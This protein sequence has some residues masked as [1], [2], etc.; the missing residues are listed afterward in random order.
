[1][2]NA[3]RDHRARRSTGTVYP[4]ETA[5]RGRRALQK[6]GGPVLL[7]DGLLQ[8]PQLSGQAVHLLLQLADIDGALNLD[9][10]DRVAVGQGAGQFHTITAPLKSSV[11]FTNTPLRPS[12]RRPSGSPAGPAGG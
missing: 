11:V 12:S 8:L 7:L 4:G 10:T 1:M 9:L 2:I 6:L 3:G 5:R